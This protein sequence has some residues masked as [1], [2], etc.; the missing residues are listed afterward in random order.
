MHRQNSKQNTTVFY[1]LWQ[2]ACS[3]KTV[4]EQ[5]GGSWVAPIDSF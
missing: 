4:K 2:A 3:K 5:C 1:T